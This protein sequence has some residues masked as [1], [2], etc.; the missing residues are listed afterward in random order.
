MTDFTTV[1]N[2]SIKASA[3]AFIKLARER[4]L[5]RDKLAAA[6]NVRNH[7]LAM[8][9][10]DAERLDI[11]NAQLLNSL[12]QANRNADVARL[13]TET[14]RNHA[15]DMAD[16]ER[17][18]MEK[19]KSQLATAQMRGDI[20]AVNF[21]LMKQAHDAFA[22]RETGLKAECGALKDT[23]ATAEEDLD[24]A[25][26]I[27]EEL[28]ED[29]GEWEALDAETDVE[30]ARLKANAGA[31]WD[32]QADLLSGI[33]N[34]TE[35]NSRLTAELASLKAPHVFKA[36]DLV[37]WG[38]C[39]MNDTI[40]RTTYCAAYMRS[41]VASDPVPLASLILVKAV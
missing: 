27:I 2:D 36:G 33:T 39:N 1:S 12:Q 24:E 28:L 10:L 13:A 41:F 8:A 3:A 29:L 22:E 18:A 16:V 5:L 23:L 37:T 20:L 17:L 30:I 38:S 9:A 35:H 25:D 31:W 21:T 14:V 40:L 15:L 26:V 32:S 11:V 4:D 34:L 19:L 7:A 6:E